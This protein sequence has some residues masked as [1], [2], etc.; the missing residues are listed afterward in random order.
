MVSRANRVMTGYSKSVKVR[1][2]GTLWDMQMYNFRHSP[3]HRD[4]RCQG[5][6][7]RLLPHSPATESCANEKANLRVSNSKPYSYH[8][9]RLHQRNQYPSHVIEDGTLVILYPPLQTQ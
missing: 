3:P 1:I 7:P 9:V 2:P 4:A 8:I 6:L 5:H